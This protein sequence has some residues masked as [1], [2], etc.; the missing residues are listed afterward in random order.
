M[1]REM[2]KWAF[3]KERQRKRDIYRARERQRE[4][5][6]WMEPFLVRLSAINV[7]GRVHHDVDIDEEEEG[8]GEGHNTGEKE[9][10]IEKSLRLEQNLRVCVSWCGVSC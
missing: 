9:R 8:E 10:G 1:D 3:M 2:K 4:S 7:V 5:E 6:K